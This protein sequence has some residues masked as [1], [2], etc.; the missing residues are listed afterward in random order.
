LIKQKIFT[1]TIK[2]IKKEKK[3]SYDPFKIITLI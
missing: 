2:I 3:S 1:A